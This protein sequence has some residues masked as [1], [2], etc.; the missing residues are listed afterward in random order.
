MT[1]ILIIAINLFSGALT[2]ILT[3]VVFAMTIANRV[4]NNKIRIDSLESKLT[5]LEDD[6]KSVSR[7]QALQTGQLNG[8][9]ANIIRIFDVLKDIQKDVKSKADK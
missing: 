3:A 8:I 1:D 7:H 2:A 5:V 9:E 4:S 6:L